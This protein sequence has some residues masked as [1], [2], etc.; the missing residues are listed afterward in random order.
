[1]HFAVL[2]LFEL[3]LVVLRTGEEAFFTNSNVFLHGQDLVQSLIDFET[4]EELGHL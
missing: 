1:M 4:G 2:F 3:G